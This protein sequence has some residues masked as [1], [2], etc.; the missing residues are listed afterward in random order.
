MDVSFQITLLSQS[1]QSPA[2]EQGRT[3]FVDKVCHDG[4][5]D[6]WMGGMSAG[7]LKNFTSGTPTICILGKA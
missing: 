4:E 3:A 1:K 2:Q 5:L 6:G 7:R